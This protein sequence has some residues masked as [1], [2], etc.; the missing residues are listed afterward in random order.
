[1]NIISESGFYK[2]NLFYFLVFI[3]ETAVLN[4]LSKIHLSLIAIK[5][6]VLRSDWGVSICLRYPKGSCDLFCSCPSVLCHGIMKHDAISI[7]SD[8]M[9]SRIRLVNFCSLQITHCRAF[10][11]SIKERSKTET[12]G[13]FCIYS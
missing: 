11:Y 6:S 7:L 2:L 3:L 1:M 8:F 9:T 5:E 13:I 10:Y 4:V 12:L